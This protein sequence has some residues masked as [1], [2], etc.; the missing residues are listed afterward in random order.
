MARD[1]YQPEFDLDYRRGQVGEKLVGT[2]LEAVGGSTLEVKTDYQAWRTGNLYIETHQELASGEWV[3][4][5]ITISK[6]TFYCFAGPNGS[7][8]ITIDKG[9]LWRIMEE[10]G[11]FVHMG[12]KGPSSRDTVGFLIRVDDVVKAIFEGGK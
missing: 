9:S 5:G 3:K 11:R 12:K 10:T 4:S 1:G 6:A 8:F 2:F 7:G